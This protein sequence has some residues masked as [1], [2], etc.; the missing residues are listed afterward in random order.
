VSALNIALR[1]YQM[2][3]GCDRT[4]ISKTV[5]AALK[6]MIQSGAE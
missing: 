3:L 2:S 5:P 6:Q 4:H 1:E